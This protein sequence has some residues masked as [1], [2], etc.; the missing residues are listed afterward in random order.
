MNYIGQTDSVSTYIDPGV[1]ASDNHELILTMTYTA[2]G[3]KPEE[4]PPNDPYTY[5][6]DEKAVRSEAKWW[7]EFRARS[8]DY[9]TADPSGY[10]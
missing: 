10:D 1:Q 6:F 8:I 2:L 7:S 5:I 9:K 4:L 3:Y